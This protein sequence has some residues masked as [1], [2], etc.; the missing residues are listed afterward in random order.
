MRLSDVA[1]QEFGW[2]ADLYKGGPVQENTLHFLHC[3]ND[4]DIDSQEVLPGIFW[5][6]DFDK[7]SQLLKY[8]EANPADFRFF[9]GYSGWGEG[10]LVDEIER[11]SWYLRKARRDLVFPGD[12]DNL[13]R[14]VLRTMGDQYSILANFPDDPRLN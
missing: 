7:L 12:P 6:G 10:Q 3:R 2:D 13:W 8:G 5:G 1:E 11:G 14:S 4:L 9:L